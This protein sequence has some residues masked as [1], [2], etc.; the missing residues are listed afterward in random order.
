VES[1]ELKVES[2]RQAQRRR[3]ETYSNVNT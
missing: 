2:V 3:V 1:G